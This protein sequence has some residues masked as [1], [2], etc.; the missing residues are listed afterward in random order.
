M[1][2]VHGRLTL[3]GACAER[4]TLLPLQDSD[5]ILVLDLGRVAEFDSPRA[6][7]ARSPTV[8]KLASMVEDTGPKSARFLRMI[9][10][11][12]IDIFG[13]PLRGNAAA[14]FEEPPSEPADPFDDANAV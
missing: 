7:L 2:G 3:P 9:A 13:R 4:G 12:A 1:P 5:R 11:G 10:N 6:L 8:G 14:A